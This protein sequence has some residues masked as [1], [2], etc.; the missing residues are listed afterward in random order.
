MYR[1]QR[2]LSCCFG[3]RSYF[4]N[5][6]LLCAQQKRTWNNNCNYFARRREASNCTILT[7]SPPIYAIGKKKPEKNSD[8]FYLSHEGNRW[9]NKW[10]YFARP[11]GEKQAITRS[12]PW[13][14]QFMQLGK[15][16]LKTFRAS[17]GFMP[18]YLLK[19]W[20][21]FNIYLKSKLY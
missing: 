9:Q 6:M 10:N 5:W 12:S 21:V 1:Q 19:N 14:H 2:K 16:S 13:A 11:G 4:D 7:V 15:R 18:I 3:K 17:K 8:G 20:D